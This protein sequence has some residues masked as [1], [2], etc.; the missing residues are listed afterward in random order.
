MTD[1]FGEVLDTAIYKEIASQAV[2]E[3]AQQRTS[4]P[5]VKELLKELAN[6]EI[7]HAE[8][9]KRLKEK[10]GA[11]ISRHSDKRADL[12]ISDYVT[13][14]ETLEGAGLQDTLIFAMKREEESVDF[15]R[16]MA[17][18]MREEE[19]RQLCANLASEEL[20][21]KN[22]L[23]VLYDQLFYKEN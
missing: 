16:K 12:K 10:G 1:E 22:R 19:A 21:H 13:G 4:D 2:Y 9:L 15:Y 6:Q 17:G 7:G 23:E 5:G 8:K 11:E 3:A 18:M 20:G 14:G